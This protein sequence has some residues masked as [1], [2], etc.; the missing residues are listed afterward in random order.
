MQNV[1]IL[2]DVV[3]VDN[4]VQEELSRVLLSGGA[5]P[6]H[7]TSYSYHDAQPAD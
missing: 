3:T 2:A 5:L 4:A 7:L 1:R 6:M